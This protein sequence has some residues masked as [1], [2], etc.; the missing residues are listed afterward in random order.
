CRYGRDFMPGHQLALPMVRDLL[1]DAAEAGLWSVRLYGG[2]P[3]LHPDLPAMVAHARARGLQV[4]VTTNGLLLDR[5]IDELVDAG[6]R[7]LTIG[8]YGTGAR[9]DAYVQRRDRFQQLER[10]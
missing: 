10:S 6:L 9:Y 3:L 4:Y 1:D 2:E 7:Q 5:R 8:F